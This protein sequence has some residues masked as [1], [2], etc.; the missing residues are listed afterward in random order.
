MGAPK[1]T[2]IIPIYNDEL[3]LSDALES[4]RRQTFTDFE[5]VCVNDGSTDKSEEIIDGFIK[6]D[7]RFLKINKKNGGV[8][9]ARNAGLDNAKGEYV[10][11]MDHDDLV[12]NYALQKLLAAAEKFNADMSRGRMTMVAENFCLKDLPKE[13]AQGKQRRFDNPIIDLKRRTLIKYRRWCWI[14]LCLFKRK[15]IESVRFVEE[16][17]S[18]GEDNLFMFDVIGRIKNY[19][20]IDDITACHRFS[21]TSVTLN[22]ELHPSLVKMYAT[23][24]PYVYEN[25]TLANGIDKRLLKWIYGWQARNA[26]KFLIRRPVCKNR[27]GELRETAREIL[28]KYNNTPEFNEIIKRWSFRQKLF[29]QLFIKQK[30]ETLRKLK[31]FL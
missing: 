27:T 25:Y 19:V 5:C 15:T 11:F 30:Y 17:R 31:I 21:A 23:I 22:G 6:N 24:I 18:G 12:P 29:F 1:I 13:N 7:D 28:M 26:Y 3:Y 20:Q 4:I 8:S 9:S 2:V 16:L 10:F 14:W